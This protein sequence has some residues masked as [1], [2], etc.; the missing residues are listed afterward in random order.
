M[1]AARAALAQSAGV[2]TQTLNVVKSPAS[3]GFDGLSH[4]DQRLAS[5]GNQLSVEPPNTSIA[6]GNG[7]ILEGVNNAV[8]VYDLTGKP[9]L[10]KVYATNEVFGL[11]PAII[12]SP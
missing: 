1:F 3:I 6:V 10:P 11:A 7:Y 8:M 4:A 12:R 2:P 5:N 9:A